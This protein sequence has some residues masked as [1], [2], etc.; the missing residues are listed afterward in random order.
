[1]HP[2]SSNK[3]LSSARRGVSERVAALN[4]QK[5]FTAEDS[6][7]FCSEF[8]VAYIIIKI[9]RCCPPWKFTANK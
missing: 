1:M 7:V 9:A 8:R 6:D 4:R 3:T 5:S 2:S